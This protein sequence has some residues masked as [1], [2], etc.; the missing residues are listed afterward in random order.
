MPYKYNRQQRWDIITG[1]ASCL[2]AGSLYIIIFIT[3]TLTCPVKCLVLFLGV[4]F[5]LLAPTLLI[6]IYKDSWKPIAQK[7]LKVIRIPLFAAVLIT[8]MITIFRT[9]E[10]LRDMGLPG[11]S[12]ALICYM[13]L[14]LILVIVT[15]IFILRRR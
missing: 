7:I 13:I 1:A 3:F 10:R 15:E 2:A 5:L 12:V 4:V 11:L 9:G 14:C 6:L 8:M